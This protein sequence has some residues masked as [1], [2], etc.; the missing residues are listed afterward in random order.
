[1]DNK[2]K[3]LQNIEDIRN[4]VF[5]GNATVTLESGKSGK[6]F[7]FKVKQSKKDDDTSPYFVSV[8]SG[9]DN[10][11][12]YSYVGIINSSKTEFKLTQK[13]KVSTDAISY[14]AFNYFFLQ[15]ITGKLNEDLHVYHSGKCGRCGRK[16][17]TPESISRGF[18]SECSSKNIKN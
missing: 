14:K 1:M 15:L 17:T 18:G 4:F 3:S 11:S 9:P 13:S 5:G 2:F 10:Y 8:L 16:L 12:N 7:T 6:H